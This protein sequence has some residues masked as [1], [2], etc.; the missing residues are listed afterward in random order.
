MSRAWET[1]DR[2]ETPDGVLE[3]R[4]RGDE[5]LITIA[6]R[7]LMNS[8]ANRSEIALATLA[9][10][11][12]RGKDAPHV[13]IGGLGIGC[14]LRAALDSLPSDAHVLVSEKNSIIAGWCRSALSDLNGAALQDARVELSLEDVSDRISA[15][16]RTFDA[17]LLD[18]YEGPHSATDAESDPFYGRKA[19]S[20]TRAALKNGILA[21]SDSK[22]E[23]YQ[24]EAT[25][26]SRI[27]RRMPP[28][29]ARRPATRRD[30]RSLLIPSGLCSDCETALLNHRER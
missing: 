14:T 1:L 12:L 27:C 18:L 29:R 11:A 28:T 26:F 2:A 16:P 17:I 23:E 22:D 8:H 15:S 6:G 10:E 19:L 7:V 21:D 30:H 5:F 13:L 4:R 9:A 24:S 3:L 20:R 25:A